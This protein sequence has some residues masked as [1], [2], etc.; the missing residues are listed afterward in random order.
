MFAS[1]ILAVGARSDSLVFL[2]A[3]IIAISL[4]S[5]QRIGSQ[6]VAA[7]SVAG[8]FLLTVVLAGL[9]SVRMRLSSVLQGLGSLE[10]ADP[11]LTANGFQPLV[12]HSLE[13]PSFLWAFVGGQ[14]PEFGPP[15]AYLRGLGWLDTGVPSITGILALTAVIAVIVWGLGKYDRK[16][17]LAVGV[18]L[19][20]L[21]GSI[22]LPLQGVNF[23]ATHVLQPRYFLPMLYVVIALAALRPAKRGHPRLVIVILIISV[24]VVANSAAQLAS[25][26]RY[27]NGE[28]LPWMRL[29]MEPNWWWLAAPVGPTVVWVAGVVAFTVFAAV[30]G[31]IARGGLNRKPVDQAVQSI[32]ANHVR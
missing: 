8:L 30:V 13:L 6:K 7:L 10:G 24:S 27:T 11:R 19:V 18:A 9:T 28:S 29:D 17:I 12:T 21:I 15:T 23:G 2:A 1:G 22:L 32:E 26:H 16:K 3:S 4:L 25:L 14:A 31:L 5:F 20:A